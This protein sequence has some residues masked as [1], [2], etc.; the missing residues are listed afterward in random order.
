MNGV[1]ST[2]CKRNKPTEAI[3]GILKHTKLRLDEEFVDGNI[4]GVLH[5]YLIDRSL[6]GPFRANE[7]QRIDRT[8]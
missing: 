4:K 5:T 3:I 8:D 2:L 6:Q 7:T 1:G